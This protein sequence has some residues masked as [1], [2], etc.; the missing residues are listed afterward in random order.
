[1]TTTT[2][3]PNWGWG[4]QHPPVPVFTEV[5]ICSACA[6]RGLS[7]RATDALIGHLKEAHERR[8]AAIPHPDSNDLRPAGEKMT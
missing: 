1:M 6:V 3:R 7:A 2:E 4:K 8:L 5:E